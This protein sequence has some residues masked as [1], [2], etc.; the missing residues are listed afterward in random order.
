MAVTMLSSSTPAFAIRITSSLARGGLAAPAS[1]FEPGGA[2]PA[3]TPEPFFA[4][5]LGLFARLLAFPGE[6]VPP[7]AA[8]RVLF[9][10]PSALIVLVCCVSPGAAPDADE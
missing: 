3:A 8:V 10:S 4:E 2:A 9:A 1:G 6:P 7:T 5:P